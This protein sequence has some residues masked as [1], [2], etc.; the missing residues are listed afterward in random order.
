VQAPFQPEGGAYGGDGHHHS[1][2]HS[3]H[4]HG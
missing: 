4:H 2:G 3:G 1:H